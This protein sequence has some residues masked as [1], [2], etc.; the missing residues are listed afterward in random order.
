M[1]PNRV[2]KRLMLFCQRE[3]YGI[4][5]FGLTFFVLLLLAVVCKLAPFGQYSL[6]AL[7]F[8]GQYY[9]MMTEKLSDYFS[10]WSW[11][12]SLGFSSFVQSSYYTNSL[13]ILLL[14]PFSEYT[15]I[16]VLDLSVFLKISLASVFFSHYLSEKYR[17]QGLLLTVF[18]VFYGLS[19]YILAFVAQP[20]WLDVVMLLPLVI[21]AWERMMQGENPL[22]YVLLLAF[23]IFSN[24]YIS[25]SLCI[26]L[27][28]LFV[29]WLCSE[30]QG[31]FRKLCRKTGTFAFSSLLAGLLC[32]FMLVPLL[33]AKQNWISSELG[34]DGTAEW[35]HSYSE[36]A[37]AFAFGAKSSREYGVAN[38][39]CGSCA[40]FFS[41]LFLLNPEIPLKKRISYTI[42]S[43][44]LFLS[45]EIN[46]LDYL[47]HGLHFP[48]QLPARQSYLFIFWM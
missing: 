5:S 22:R 44:F 18:G 27:V 16:A 13:F 41:L 19:S 3:K 9:P 32:A 2:Q 29:V 31:S 24:F 36:I 14:K 8:H 30:Y 12:G 37:D 10:V 17:K 23:T 21:L 33:L 34:F 43:V 39:Y 47:W 15:R 48:N 46:V 45:F 26:F 11:N 1:K 28:L 6:L 20:M 25:I 4:V 38:L 42:L 40:V 7:D 35:Y